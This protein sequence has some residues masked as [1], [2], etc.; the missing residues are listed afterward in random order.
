MELRGRNCLDF[1]A[2]P[3]T[4]RANDHAQRAT[5]GRSQ[6]HAQNRLQTRMGDGLNALSALSEAQRARERQRQ[7]RLAGLQSS[8]GA[9]Y[10]GPLTP[11]NRFRSL[12]TPPVV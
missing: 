12:R 10:T 2:E 5:G 8:V 4:K 7:A 3:K 11:A 6:T 1:F 9:G